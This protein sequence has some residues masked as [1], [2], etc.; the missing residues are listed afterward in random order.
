MNKDYL[1]DKTGNDPEI[2]RFENALKTFRQS[3]TQAPPKVAV[4]S[5]EKFK[6]RK[7]A[8]PLVFGFRIASFAMIAVA[9]LAIGFFQVL[10][11]EPTNRFENRAE[12][13]TEEPKGLVQQQV[14]PDDKTIALEKPEAKTIGPSKI[15]ATKVRH[16]RRTPIKR[17]RV[18]K[19][20]RRV[21]RKSKR[22]QKAVGQN[23]VQVT[24]LTAEEK[25]AYEQLMLG[26]S[27]T[28]SN[29]KSVKDK[30][31]GSD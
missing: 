14:R 24:E 2:E 18:K 1:W 3:D 11:M 15:K 20:F 7:T 19:T 12:S 6:E 16:L 5:F 22:R 8:R 9:I 10:K 28:S 31:E 21:K 23:K 30:V 25:Y 4:E 26:L 13:T 29:L 17:A 27:I